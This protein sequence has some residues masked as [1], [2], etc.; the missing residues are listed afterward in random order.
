[1]Y[2]RRILINEEDRSRILG[3]HQNHAKRFNLNFGRLNEAAAQ[4]TDVAAF[5]E[6][7]VNDMGQN[8]GTKNTLGRGPGVD[9][10]FGEKT[11]AA[12]TTYGDQYEQSKAGGGASTIKI[13]NITFKTQDGDQKYTDVNSLADAIKNKKVTMDTL[14]WWPGINPNQRVAIKSI[15][16]TE[17]A[18]ITDTLQAINNAMGQI[19]PDAPTVA[20]TYRISINRTNNN[21]ENLSKEQIIAKMNQDEAFKNAIKNDTAGYIYTDPQGKASWQ[22]IKAVP[23]LTND[24]NVAIGVADVGQTTNNK[25]V[26]QWLASSI[27]Q[28]W[29]DFDA[30]GKGEKYLDFLERHGNIPP[31]EGGKDAFRQL[32]GTKADNKLAGLRRRVKKGVEAFRKG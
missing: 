28:A 19:I 22:S 26:D 30:E 12:W 25:M 7:A 11:Q 23:E 21:V 18:K 31:V 5:Q 10:V 3:M 1:M 32:I 17:K 2:N 6:W 24:I 16:E 13:E 27:G 9:G 15:P 29:K 4:P 14:V 8:L 20:K